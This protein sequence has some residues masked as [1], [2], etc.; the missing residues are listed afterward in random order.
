V[1][2]QTTA[3]ASSHNTIDPKTTTSR[4]AAWSPAFGRASSAIDIKSG[5]RRIDSSIV[6]LERMLLARFTAM[7]STSR[8]AIRHR[9]SSP[10]ATAEPGL[11]IAMMLSPCQSA[12]GE[13]RADTVTPDHF[14]IRF[15]GLTISKS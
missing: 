8:L 10:D 5:K 15:N 9:A 1:T 13:I 6:S 7:G 4:D 14:L 12:C 2:N 3:T 11:S